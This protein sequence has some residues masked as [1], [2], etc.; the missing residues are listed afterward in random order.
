MYLQVWDLERPGR[1]MERRKTN[2]GRDR[3]AAGIDGLI[4]C[5]A[6]PNDNGNVFAVGSYSGQV[7]AYTR[8]NSRVVFKANAQR[9]GV[10]QITYSECGRFLWAGGRRSSELLC[11]D[12]R[13]GSDSV[14]LW[15][16]PRVCKSNQHIQFALIDHDEQM[17]CPLVLSG[18]S[19]GSEVECFALRGGEPERVLV[20]VNHCIVENGC[21]VNGIS[22]NMWNGQLAIS[23]GQRASPS[24]DLVDEDDDQP[25]SNHSELDSRSGGLYLLERRIVS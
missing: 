10:T 5:F 9:A 2:K 23:T 24:L 4:S 25:L 18:H 13:A 8:E 15:R 12:V 17:G 22:I 6:F 16:V 11:W 7:A 3:S 1:P 14:P 20:N 19:L 21:I